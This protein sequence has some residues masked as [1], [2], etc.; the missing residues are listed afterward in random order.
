MKYGTEV[1]VLT[2]ARYRSGVKSAW[3]WSEVLRTKE[4]WA[5]TDDNLYSDLEPGEADLVDDEASAERAHVLGG[6]ANDAT[7]LSMGKRE[8]EGGRTHY[9]RQ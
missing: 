3:G 9:P 4:V 7:G 2:S 1:R 5:L 6:C 8:G